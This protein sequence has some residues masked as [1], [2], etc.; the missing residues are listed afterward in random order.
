MNIIEL[1][2]IV[3]GILTTVSFLPQVMKTWRYRSAKDL[4]LTMFI[5]FCLGVFLWLIYG[6]YV[7]SK[8]IIVANFVTFILAGTI[9]YFKIKYD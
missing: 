5:C 8:P 3:A 4:S 2:G 6:I 7:S 1:I 9:L